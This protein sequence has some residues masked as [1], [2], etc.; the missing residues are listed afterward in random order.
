[1]FF[2]TKPP[3]L[4]GDGPAALL[5]RGGGGLGRLARGLG[6]AGPCPMRGGVLF[7][8]PLFLP[9]AGDWIAGRKLWVLH[10]RL[11]PVEVRV[12][13]DRR[14]LRLFHIPPGFQLAV[15]PG[16]MDTPAAIAH[17]LLNLPLSQVAG[18]DAGV[19]A[20]H[21]AHLAVKGGFQFLNRPG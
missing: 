7:L 10:D 20:L 17:S 12:G 9:Q 3:Q 1:M 8:Q 13:L 5:C 18:L 21:L 14:L 16:L 2:V 4:L 19:L 11:L 15:R 6:R